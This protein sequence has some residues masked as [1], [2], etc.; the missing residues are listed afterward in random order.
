MSTTNGER[1]WLLERRRCRSLTANGRWVLD[2]FVCCEVPVEGDAAVALE[3]FTSREGAEA[4]LRGMESL[5]VRGGFLR[6]ARQS[7]GRLAG[8][9]FNKA[10]SE[11]VIELL[12][13]ELLE[14]LEGSNVAYVLIDPPP[15]DGPIPGSLGLK[16]APAF[17]RELRRHLLGTTIHREH[18]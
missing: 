1:Y 13:P 18:A 16:A 7:G 5:A 9:E 10:T 3:V 2:H 17:A 6:G 4:E 8:G 14:I 15:V 11:E 12:E